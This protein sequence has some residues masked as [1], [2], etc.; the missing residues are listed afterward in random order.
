[1]IT[2]V[3]IAGVADGSKASV[4]VGVTNGVV[5]SMDIGVVAVLLSSAA[6]AHEPASQSARPGL[7]ATQ[8]Q[9]FP[10]D[11]Y[12][13][14]ELKILRIIGFSPVAALPD[15][16]DDTDGKNSCGNK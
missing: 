11:E 5:V 14:I 3:W 16:K 4:V 1:M 7:S 6:Y 12:P 8:K 9:V 10:A 15:C 2:G 13:E